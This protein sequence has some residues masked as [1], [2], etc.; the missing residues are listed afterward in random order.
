MTYWMIEHY[1][2]TQEH[3][4]LRIMLVGSVNGIDRASLTWSTDPQ[5]AI[6]FARE[7][8]AR[9]FALLHPEWCTLCRI[10]SHRDVG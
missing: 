8:D 3:C 7:E 9:A 2:Y 5:A 10:T 6:H 4:W 1:D